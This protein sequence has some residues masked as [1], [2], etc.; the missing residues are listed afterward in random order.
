MLKLRLRRI[1]RKHDPSFRIVVTESSAP[2]RGKYLESVGSYNPRLKQLNLDKERI[3]HW[4]DN[5][6]QPTD[7]VHNIFVRENI[8]EG[9]KVAVHS[10]KPSKKVKEESAKEPV[11]AAPTE[12]KAEEAPADKESEGETEKVEEEKKEEAPAEEEPKDEGEKAEEE[13]KEDSSSDLPAEDPARA[14]ESRAGGSAQAGA[15]AKEEASV[16]EDKKE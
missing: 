1:G 5:G 4:L 9:K 15:S 10:N 2:A 8:I 7:S 12:D 6:A 16:E 11:A 13:K 14:S 3:Q